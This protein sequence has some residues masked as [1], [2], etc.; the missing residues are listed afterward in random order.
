MFP[1]V[2]RIDM[3]PELSTISDQRLF[4]EDLWSVGLP[5]KMHCRRMLFVIHFRQQVPLP[6]AR[7]WN[8]WPVKIATY[9]TVDKS[10]E[11]FTPVVHGVI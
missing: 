6:G 11:S 1:Y 7:P 3:M 9:M 10:N 5:K 2:I 4:L 8:R